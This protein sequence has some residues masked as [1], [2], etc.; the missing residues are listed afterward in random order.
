MQGLGLKY[1]TRIRIIYFLILLIVGICLV[2]VGALLKVRNFSRGDVHGSDPSSSSSLENSR[3]SF[4]ENSASAEPHGITNGHNIDKFDILSETGT[5]IQWPPLM[6]SFDAA[7]YPVYKTLLSAIEEWN[8]DQPD[9][10][11][12]FTETLQHF[13]YSN[14]VERAWALEFRQAEVPF[15]MYD[16][17]EFAATGA[18]W[19]NKYLATQFEG[20]GYSATTE[21]SKDNHFMFWSPK[22]N[23]YTKHFHFVPPTK[24]G[25]MSWSQ[26]ARH[27]A[28]ADA[29][30][31]NFAH[32]PSLQ[33][34]H[35]YRT[36]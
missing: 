14:P 26:W 33:N 9:P 19:S 1:K 35:L 23:S 7:T 4:R 22:K 27:A 29:L 24:K 25:K 10:P 21:T 28:N 6:K 13:N 5:K 17:P 18:K 34:I 36:P 20:A 2:Y 30:K 15:K 32:F 11:A 16:V 3:F 8:P 31:V 12:H